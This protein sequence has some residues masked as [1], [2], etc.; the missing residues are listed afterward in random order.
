[1]MGIIRRQRFSVFGKDHLS[2]NPTTIFELSAWP[3]DEALL[4]MTRHEAHDEVTFF[5]FNSGI[6]VRWFSNIKELPLCGHAALA[7]SYYLKD[8]IHHNQLIELVNFPNQLWLYHS[9]DVPSIVFKSLNG[10]LTKKESNHLFC[11]YELGRD[12]LIVFEAI[13]DLIHFDIH[14]FDWQSIA[15]IGVLVAVLHDQTISFRFFAPKAGLG[16][17]IASASVLPSLVS[18]IRHK[19]LEPNHFL[20]KQ[21]SGFN[22]AFKVFDNHFYTFVSGNVFILT[23]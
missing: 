7:L 14:S 23:I 11:T 13:E 10:E 8:R 15:Q 1:M 2:G 12:L 18:Y 4:L 9:K 5:T 6:E 3:S 17:D 16:E 21:L 20:F 19:G 22:V